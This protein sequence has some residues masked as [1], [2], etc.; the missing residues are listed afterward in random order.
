MHSTFSNI[1]VE[2]QIMA[3]ASL[4][5]HHLHQ[6]CWSSAID[7]L[8]PSPTGPTVPDCALL[9]LVDSHYLL[10]LIIRQLKRKSSTE[11]CGGGCCLISIL[12]VRFDCLGISSGWCSC[13]LCL[14]L[15]C[16]CVCCRSSVSWL[17]SKGLLKSLLLWPVNPL[18]FA[19]QGRV[20]ENKA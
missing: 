1:C 17:G 3:E 10:Q 7:C 18:F 12:E 13:Y 20:R 9:C 8:P 16:L 19:N 11:V 5:R 4:E 6:C 2:I 15:S 14:K